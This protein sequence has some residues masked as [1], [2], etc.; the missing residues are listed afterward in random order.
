ML[1][2]DPIAVPHYNLPNWEVWR[3]GDCQEHIG[4]ILESA[5]TC[6]FVVEMQYRAEI[7][8][9]KFVGTHAQYDKIDVETVNEY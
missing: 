9:V 6:G 8:W 3:A 7:T 4:Q 1:A 2:L 5:G